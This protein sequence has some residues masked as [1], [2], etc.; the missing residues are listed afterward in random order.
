MDYSQ[1]TINASAYP[2][3]RGSSSSG[4]PSSS[5]YNYGAQ[6]GVGGYT[7]KPSAASNNSN[8][9]NHNA[10]NANYSNAY[11][12]GGA[13]SGYSGG[14]GSGISPPPK[15]PPA[16]APAGQSSAQHKKNLAAKFGKR[17]GLPIP[18]T[19]RIGI[20]YHMD[21]GSAFSV[22]EIVVTTRS[23]GAKTFAMIDK[24]L[25]S[26][27]YD[28]K[29]GEATAETKTAALH[30]GVSG[31]NIGK[32]VENVTQIVLLTDIGT[33]GFTET[34]A[35]IINKAVSIQRSRSQGECGPPHVLA[36]LLDDKSG[37]ARQ[38]LQASG[39]DIATG[40]AET[41][42]VLKSL[43]REQQQPQSVV[44][45]SSLKRDIARAQALSA[46]V[47]DSLISVDQ[48]LIAIVG[49]REVSS[50]LAKA[51]ITEDKVKDAA[52]KIRTAAKQRTPAGGGGDGP[53]GDEESVIAQYATDVVQQAMDG[54]LDPVIG[55]DEE[56]SRVVRVLS[57][58][59]KNNPVLIGEPGVGKTAIV[60]GLAQRIVSGDVPTSLMGCRIM[61]LD[62][63]ALIA[64]AKLQ[65]EFEERLKAVLQEVAESNGRLILFIDEIHLVL[66]AG[67][68][69][70]GAM[71]AANLL[72]PLLARGELRTIG[73]TTLGEY[74]K[75]IEKDS[76][77]ERR[78]QQVYVPEASVDTAISILRGIKDKYESH[79]GVRIMD[80][81]LVAAATL[82]H[83]YIP[84]RFL[85]DKAIDLM[86]EA[87]ANIRVELDSQPDVIDQV[88]RK[89]ARLEI[90]EKLLEREDDAESKDRLVD[91]RAA[92]AQTREEGTTLKVRLNVQK[93]RIK[94]MRSVKAEIDDITAKIAKYEKPDAL[95]STNNPMYSTLIL[96][97]SDG[98][99]EK[100]HLDMVVN[101]KYHDLPRL[102]ASYESLVQQNE[103]DE[104]RLFTEI[105]G[106]D[107]IAEIVARWTGIP[108]NRLTQS[109]KDRILDLGERLNAQVIGQERTIAAVANAVLRSRAGL[110]SAN[111]PSGCFLFLGPTGVGKTETAR[112]LARELFNDEKMLVRLDMSE[113]LEAHSVYRL[114]GAP[115]GYVGYDQGGQLTE[116]VRRRP[117]SVVL[118][119]E[120]EKAHPQVWNSLLQVMDDGRLTD[121]Q[122]RVVD[123]KNTV[124]ILTSNV[125]AEHLLGGG[126]QGGVVCKETKRAVMGIVKQVFPPE[127]LNRIDEI[128]MFSPLTEPKLA[129]ILRLQFATYIKSL[130]ERKIVVEM[131]DSAAALLVRSAYTPSM[132]ARPLKRLLERVVMTSLSK[133]ML[134]GVLDNGCKV[135]VLW[136]PFPARFTPVTCFRE[137]LRPGADRWAGWD[138]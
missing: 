45:S 32:I 132:G 41:V 126:I 34:S 23:T 62:M 9:Q 54:K 47:G 121:G 57:R 93:E 135:S 136:F 51:G 87:C 103:E 81:A 77:F 4:Y 11:S 69:S 108:V 1:P 119:D 31:H 86:D 102:Q 29:V 44:P 131:D 22:G 14:H 97:D 106:P 7:S 21:A 33:A 122:G 3:R 25:D 6:S 90:E 71:D 36:A 48:L 137:S 15:A 64:G 130:E 5:S 94:L 95:H 128:A 84:G 56:I 115:P 107:Q 17:I 67:R 129:G 35:E 104:N 113:Y 96:P 123:F 24:A 30:R 42:A 134:R 91:V 92:L 46:A 59:T 138:D 118:C 72:K 60:E 101:L 83:R 53:A 16:A 125:G 70:D 109:E 18:D 19:W 66:G 117:Y 10:N 49:D 27:Q 73:A 75:Y 38:V 127:F 2:G 88:E 12:A 76:A 37:L 68:S 120:I 100:D 111:R 124:I 43:P 112:A 20:H 39:G 58:R 105:V 110:S 79:H 99:N 50:F 63:G 61:S 74:R 85:P 89:L 114:I 82:S 116:A 80:T 13:T 40:L 55:R 8:S 28:V 65:G 52:A 78:F 26:G 133:L 98:Y